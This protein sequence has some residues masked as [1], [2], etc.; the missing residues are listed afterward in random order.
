MCIMK[1]QVDLVVKTFN[2][3]NKNLKFTF[4]IEFQ[5]RIN[6]LDI[7]LIRRRHDIITDWYQ[8]DVASGRLINFNSHHTLQQKKNIIFNITDRAIL[9]SHNKFHMK[10]KEKIVKLLVDNGYPVDFIN[11]NID[12]RIKKIQIIN[13]EKTITEKDTP[14]NFLCLPFK[15]NFYF[16]T[17]ILKKFNVS[18]IPIVEKSLNSIIRLGKDITSKW[19]QINVVYK[20]HCKNCPASYIGET[21]RSLKTRINEHKKHKNQDSVVSVHE[22]EKLHE[23]DWNNIKILDQEANYNKRLLS[24]MIHINRERNSINRKEDVLNLSTTYFSLL[25]I[26][27]SL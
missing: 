25:R 22:R 2:S 9:L 7:T 18:T 27:N 3:W 15:S 21:K 8:K 1:D 23:F 12:I 6:F 19:D 17:P 24:E 5:N 13:A 20:I 11:K 10:N 26:F 16:L 4:E 14:S